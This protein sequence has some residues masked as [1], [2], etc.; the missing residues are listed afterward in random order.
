MPN[1]EVSGLWCCFRR[2]GRRSRVRDVEEAVIPDERTRLMNNQS[3]SDAIPGPSGDCV[4]AQSALNERLERIVRAKESKMV[5]IASRAPFDICEVSESDEGATPVP[6]VLEAPTAPD[7]DGHVHQVDPVVSLTAFS[8]PGPPP[9]SHINRRPPILTMTPAHSQTS[10][11][12]PHY[13]A[14]RT[15]TTEDS[16]SLSRGSSRSSSR[17][18]YVTA[19]YRFP[20]PP[21]SDAALQN[22]GFPENVSRVSLDSLADEHFN[23]T[24]RPAAAA[25]AQSHSGITLEW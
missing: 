17:K 13:S 5:N 12:S 6:E 7:T 3:D 9:A 10:I 22:R 15:A 4:A 20:V 23:H 8:R 14:P 16:R 2:R 19:F 21:A 18:R 24:P 1:P 11:L 25:E